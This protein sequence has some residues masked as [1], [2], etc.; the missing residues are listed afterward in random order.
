MQ[1]IPKD[2]SLL[3]IGSNDGVFLK[4]LIKKVKAIGI[5]PSINV[6]KIANNQ[7]F[8]THIGFFD[9]KTLKYSYQNMENLII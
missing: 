8:T 5:D 6:G 2:K 7:G 1:L 4:P 3:D 9:D